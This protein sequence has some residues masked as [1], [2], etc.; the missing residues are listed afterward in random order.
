[1]NQFVSICLWLC[2]V[3]TKLHNV[4]FIIDVLL[5]YIFSS[6]QSTEFQQMVDRILALIEFYLVVL[7][8]PCPTY[9]LSQICTNFDFLI[10]FSREISA[11]LAETDPF[12]HAQRQ[13]ESETVAIC[14]SRFC[15]V[16]LIRAMSSVLLEAY[17][18][19]L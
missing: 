18:L 15:L 6:L 3:G 11:R 13:S 14:D 7:R 16:K 4:P 17:D 5:I 10:D 8:F 12:A 9:S 1:M 2:L 19:R